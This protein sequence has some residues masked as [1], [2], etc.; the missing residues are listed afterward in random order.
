MND[1]CIVIDWT[2]NMSKVLPHASNSSQEDMSIYQDTLFCLWA[3]RSLLLHL[4]AVCGEAANTNL[5]IL[6][7]TRPGTE[8]TTLRTLGEHAYHYTIDAVSF[9]SRTSCQIS[10]D[11]EYMVFCIQNR[12]FMLKMI[13]MS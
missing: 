11:K 8:P 1:P 12:A 10:F 2:S 4:N 7:L 5:N 3:D 13:E 9:S 6:G